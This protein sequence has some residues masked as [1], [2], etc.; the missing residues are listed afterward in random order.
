MSVSALKLISER[1]EYLPLTEQNAATL[2]SFFK[3]PD[4]RFHFFGDEYPPETLINQ[5]IRNNI[6]THEQEACGL[7]LAADKRTGVPIGFG[8]LVYLPYQPIPEIH[9]AVERPYRRIGFGR[10]ITE[11]LTHYTF[12]QQAFSVVL[13]SVEHTNDPAIR[14]LLRCQFHLNKI[15]ARKG[16]WYHQFARL[17]AN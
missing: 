13:A 6:R 11:R 1:L 8:G 7:W 16:R 2:K 15:L 3:D 5:F 14:L 17:P 9:L 4:I 10:E 12:Y